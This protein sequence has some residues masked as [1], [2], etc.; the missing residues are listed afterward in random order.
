M[1]TGLVFQPFP[2]F[3]NVRDKMLKENG[4]LEKALEKEF[5]E[6]QE[7]LKFPEILKIRW[8]LISTLFCSWHSTGG[9]SSYKW[10][11]QDYTAGFI[12]AWSCPPA[13]KN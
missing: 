10:Q 12:Y 2:R 5:I 3:E 13:N 1:F 7:I 6:S 11:R 4:H 8:S 9:V